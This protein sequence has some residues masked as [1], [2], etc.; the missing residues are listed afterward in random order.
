MYYE[1]FEKLCQ[2]KAVKPSAV[3]KETGIATSTLSEWKN[4][5]YTPKPDKLQLIADYFCVSIDYLMNGK[6]LSIEEKYGADYAHL[7]AQIR[8]DADLSKALLKYFELPDNK[9]KHVVELINLL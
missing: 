8:D 3:S 6:E 5:G 1:N 4:G 7:V 9:K 2:S